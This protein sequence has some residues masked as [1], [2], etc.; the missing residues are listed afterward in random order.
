[1]NVYT[2]SFFGHREIDNPEETEKRLT[3]VI[4]DIIKN[5][6]YVKFLIGRNGEFDW[7][8]SAVISRITHGN[9]NSYT[10][11]VLPYMKASY[12]DHKNNFECCYNEVEICTESSSAH[13]KS[14]IQICNRNMVDRSD[15][16]VCFI[17]HNSGGAYK[18]VQY[19]VKQNK[20]II[21]IGNYTITL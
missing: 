3:D 8:A 1:M 12:R 11:L 4:R 16:V 20:K 10:V 15:L 13:Y 17:D 6:G 19:A 2:V 18:T 7:L 5:N 21:N 14:A 9:Q